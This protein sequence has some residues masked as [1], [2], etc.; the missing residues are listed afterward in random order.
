[1]IT[2]EGGQGKTRLAIQVCQQLRQHGWHSGFLDSSL[3]ANQISSLWRDLR[4]L[5]QQMFI[6]V[7]YAETRQKAFLS[8][9]K[10]TLQY[11]PYK[12]VRLLLLAR[13][14]GEWW[15]LLQSTNS[16][17]EALLN[18][19][20]TTGPFALSPLYEQQQDRQQAFSSALS[21]FAETL[22]VQTP[23]IV[24]ELTGNQFARP[25]FVQM[26]ALLALYGERP[27]T[28]QG[29]TKALLNHERRY[30]V[31]LLESTNLPDPARGAEQ[32]LA[33]ATLAGGFPTGKIQ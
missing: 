29:L 9:L 1:L 20:A 26:G 17:C 7:D 33:L 21:A 12:A 16:D 23:Q 2:G 10:V 30:W 4:A 25:L 14:G 28:S 11:P 18:G 24:P 32:L 6:V 8:L 19:P 5:N 22:Q 13:N 3:A 27:A 15:D 31:G